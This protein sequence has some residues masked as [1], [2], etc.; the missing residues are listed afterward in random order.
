MNSMK[1]HASALII[2]IFVMS[3]ACINVSSRDIVEHFELYFKIESSEEVFKLRSLELYIENL[4]LG[5]FSFGS[6]VV[7]DVVSAVKAFNMSE[8]EKGEYTLSFRVT[9]RIVDASNTTHRISESLS[10]NVKV[11]EGGVTVGLRIIKERENYKI[12]VGNIYNPPMKDEDVLLIRASVLTKDDHRELVEAIRENQ[13]LRE[14]LLEEFNSTGNYAYY[15][16]Y[17]DLS[18]PIRAFADLGRE[19]ELTETELKILTLTLKANN[20][21]YS[22][23]TPPNKSYYIVAFSN[24][25]P[26]DFIPK[27]ES[28]FQ[29]KLP[30]VYYKGRGFYPYP[31]TAVNWITSYFNRRDYEKGIALL[32]EL[33]SLMEVEELN[34]KKYALF[35]V[36]FHYRNSS[37]PWVSSFSQGI[38]AGLYAKAYNITKNE[39]YLEKAQLLMNSFELKGEEGFVINTTYGTW[40]LEYNFD[41]TF[42]VLNGHI[43]TMK[44]LYN[45]YQVTGDERALELFNEGVESVKKALKDCDAGDW[46]LYSV[47]GLRASESY[48]RL[49]IELL[50]WLYNTTGDR[51]FLEYAE[52]WKGYIEKKG[53]T[54]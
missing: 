8:I 45:Y 42:L 54:P 21:Y 49:H 35:K 34:G 22:N 10:T 44:G 11:Q 28:K 3:S 6:I 36:Y 25:T 53:I 19:R 9:G 32:N 37:I 50:V 20:A 43:I 41:P 51:Y 47:K 52:K 4:T 26:Y 5:N 17:I 24:E 31:V 16:S 7:D 46:S 18:Y 38:A 13:R 48:H 1:K 40:F 14:K 39:T 15:R 27:I 30:F 33:D 29:S 2:V 23:H 12:K